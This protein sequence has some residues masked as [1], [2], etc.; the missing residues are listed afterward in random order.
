[1]LHSLAGNTAQWTPQMLT[2]DQLGEPLQSTFVGMV[3]R[4]C[5]RTDNWP[6]PTM[7]PMSYRSSMR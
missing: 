5:R 2:F 3:G 1:L 6:P 4:M 7:Q